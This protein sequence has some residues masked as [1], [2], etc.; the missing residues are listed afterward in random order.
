MASLWTPSPLGL[1][2]IKLWRRFYVA[3]VGPILSVTA[4]TEWV[5]CGCGQFLHW[6]HTNDSWRST[7]RKDDM[8]WGNAYEQTQ[9]SSEGMNLPERHHIR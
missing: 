6:K 3:G 5:G 4:L 2:A 1:P 8:A 9:G 7:Y